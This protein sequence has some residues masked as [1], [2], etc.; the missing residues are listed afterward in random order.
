MRRKMTSAILICL[1]L[2]FLWQALAQPEG[3]CEKICG[4]HYRA[5]V[6]AI[7]HGPDVPN[8]VLA[9]RACGQIYRSCRGNCVTDL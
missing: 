3:P 2:G 4:E 5:C 7:R 8:P 6:E 1:G 9:Q